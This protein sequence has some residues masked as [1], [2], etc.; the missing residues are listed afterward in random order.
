MCRQ[1]CSLWPDEASAPGTSA[2]TVGRCIPAT[3]ISAFPKLDV[4]GSNRVGRSNASTVTD[5]RRLYGPTGGR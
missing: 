4:A 5:L 2:L 3:S 1:S